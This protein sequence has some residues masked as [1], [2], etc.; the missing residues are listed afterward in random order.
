MNL[1]WS[2]FLAGM[3]VLYSG[4]VQ[5]GSG[6][7]ACVGAGLYASLEACQMATSS[8]SCEMT[9]V[10]IEA[11]AKA[12]VCWKPKSGQTP[13]TG[14]STGGPTPA[15]SM[16][17]SESLYKSYPYPEYVVLNGSS[18]TLVT[19]RFNGNHFCRRSGTS[20]PNPSYS[21]SCYQVTTLSGASQ[22][23]SISAPAK[24]VTI[25]TLNVYEKE[26]ADGM[27]MCQYIGPLATAQYY[28]F[29]KQ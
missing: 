26:S 28:C 27:Q 17:A 19:Q 12:T 24:A 25:G 16:S 5:M 15:P 14:T 3:S 7:L 10:Q 6:N 23:A 11:A 1:K 22:Y 13:T 4:C 8:L 29:Q 21:Y 18:G 2:G 9:T 20:G